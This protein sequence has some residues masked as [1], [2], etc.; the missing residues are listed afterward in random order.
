MPTFYR[1]FIFAFCLLFSI[2]SNTQTVLYPGDIILFSMYAD[3]GPCGLPAMTDQFSFMCFQDLE[4]GTQIDITDNGWEHSNAGFWGDG[5]GTLAMTRSGGLIPKG[6]VITVESRFIAGAWTYRTISPD[7]Q[8]TFTNLN[9]P[10]GDFNIDPMGDQIVFMQGG[11]WDN[12]G[13]GANRALYDGR[14][15]WGGNSRGEWVADGTNNGSNIPPGLMPCY[16]QEVSCCGTPTQAV[17]YY[18]PTGPATHFEWLERIKWWPDWATETNCNLLNAWMP[19]YIDASFTIEGGMGIGCWVC[20]GC[21]TFE[22]ALVFTMPW[23]GE[24]NVTYTNGIDTF[25]SLGVNGTY[26]EQVF[27]SENISY[28]IISVEA[29][30]GC[31]VYSNFS[32]PANLTAPYNDPGLH[33]DLWACEGV[34]YY[35]LYYFLN[36]TPDTGGQWFPPLAENPFTGQEFYLGSMPPGLY[37]YVFLH[38]GPPECPPDTASV[39]VHWV[40]ISESIIEVGCHQNGTPYDITDDR[41]EL[42]L[43]ILGE[44]FGSMYEL[45]AFSGDITPTTGLTGVPTTFLF[46]PGTAT[47]PMMSIHV[48]ALNPLWCSFILDIPIP[49]YCSDPCDMNMLTSISGTEDVCIQNCAVEPDE[50]MVSI[51]GGTPPFTMDF[52][53][54]AP[55]FPPW[56]F[57]AAGIVSGGEIAV[58][59]DTVPA[60]IYNA[61]GGVLI[62]PQALAG[63][64]LTFTLDQIYDFYGCNGSLGNTE[65]TFYIHSLPPITTTSIMVCRDEA[66]SIDLTEYDGFISAF[67][68]V[69]WFDG[70]PFY[71]GEQIFNAT[72]ANLEN[73]VQLWALIEDDYC[74][75]AIQVPFVIFPQPDIDSIPPIVICQ[76]DVIAL[77]SLNIVDAGNSMAIYSFHSSLPPDSTNLLDPQV[78]MP[79]DSTTIYLLATAGICFDTLPIQIFVEDY[80]DF[81]LEALPCNLLSGTYSVLFTSSADSIISS[82]GTVINNAIGQDTIFGIPNDTSITIELL[83]PTGL[84]RDTIQI[85]APNCN[86]PQINQPVPGAAMYS[87]CDGEA[88]PLMTVTVDPGL[89]AN[90]YTVPSGGVAFLQNSLTYQPVVSA[91]ATYYVEALDPLTDCYSVRT[92]LILRVYPLAILTHPADPVVCDGESFDLNAIVPGVQNGVMG[93]GSWFSLP[94]NQPAS[95]MVQPIAGQSWYYLFTSNP[96]GCQS[97]DTIAATVNPVPDIDLYDILCDDVLLTYQLS[98]TSDADV[99]LTSNGGTLV[100]VAGTDSFTVE[101]IPYNTDIQFDLEYTATGCT[102]S[103]VIAAPDCSCPGLLDATD[104]SGCSDQGTIDLTQF[105]GPG[106]NG[107]WQIVSVP[108]GSNPAILNGSTFE[109]SSAD[110]GDYTLLFIRSIILAD[111]IDSATFELTLNTSPYADAGTDGMVCAP[112][113]INLSG[114]AGGSNVQFSW[115]TNGNGTI[116]NPNALVTSYMPT[117][118]DITAGMVSFTL[119]ATDQSGFCPS[120]SETITIIIDGSAYYILNAG[121]QTYCD[122]TD[123]LIDL[124]PLIS[125][126]TTGGVWFFPDTVSAPVTGSSQIN[127]S[128]LAPGTYTIFY[129]TTNAVAPCKNDTTG[130]NLIIENCECPSVAV[131]VPAGALCSG[132]DMLDLNTLKLTG[133][134]GVWTIVSTPPGSM[135]AVINGSQF[136]T[137]NSDGGIYRIRFRLTNPV[138]GCPD[139]SEVNLEVV[140]TPVI[141]LVSTACEDGLQSWEAIVSSTGTIVTSSQGTVVP[142][143]GNRYRIENIALLTP[144]VVTSS[145][146][147]GLCTSTLNVQPADCECTLAISNLPDE[148]MLCANETILLESSVDDPKGTV[149]SFWIVANDSLYQD[150]LLVTEAGQY[151]F[152][153]FDALGCEAQHT[154]D[155]SYYVEMVPAISWMDVN[156]PGD[157]DG[158]IAIEAIQ[159]GIGPYYISVNGGVQQEMTTFPYILDGLSPGDYMLE[160]YDGYNCSTEV[161]ISIQSASSETLI[162]GADLTILVGDSVLINPLLSFNPDSF[163]WVGDVDNLLAPDQLINWIK[164]EVNQAFQLYAIDDKGCVYAD[165]LTIKV[166]LESSIYVANVF[167]P[168]GDGLNDILWPSPDPSVT[169][170]TYFE[171]YSRWGELVYSVKDQ[172]PDQFTAGWDGTMRGQEMMA[173]VYVYRAGALNKRGDE[174]HLAG[175]VTIIR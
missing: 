173:G 162:L 169:M 55:S 136:M 24:Y 103:F 131:S 6:T 79:S 164:P 60:P 56:T 33:G 16:T 5:E 40:D 13:G 161:S 36:G 69:S 120:A 29:V 130:V 38:P 159:G 15:I 127:P 166:L 77:Q 135:P 165:D 108:P 91:N 76:G 95:G 92:P 50:F 141:S 117:L 46:D 157:H 144:I 72:A 148:V 114:T 51:E 142:L 128:T 149:T 66:L 107:S 137:S 119:T 58:C 19:N 84:C 104:Y 39:S 57:S 116:V 112:D 170:I 28:W 146:G 61:A 110:P 129:T 42:T 124:D 78:Y 85:T 74:G 1:S 145:N 174:F 147:N 73:V 52:T 53:L 64:S 32:G 134:P 156:C 168:N 35:D 71:G 9:V 115:Q 3:M 11:T 118:A 54:T 98:F 88:I 48:T 126:G 101:S 163:Y 31:T 49:G 81:T 41:I 47:A 167:S 105:E 140:P 2:K 63:S 80:P 152:W 132:S 93:T 86:C 20:S 158:V 160:L 4:T 154:V 65:H 94:G 106:V 34:G 7:N 23:D 109:G 150:D 26:G 90:W 139:F 37:R 143:G 82:K 43:T 75:N 67:Y 123:M 102:T 151:A 175:D 83:N 44:G 17:K 155:V 45:S 172:L 138:A 97:R 62:I 59:V 121:S 68:D 153:A 89:E 18:G 111:C 12:Q 22:D 70:H 122:T 125:F 8:W 133:E 10:G 113:A 27:I 96:G 30:G 171:I 14:L 21:A 87:I 100:Q 25:Q 99:V